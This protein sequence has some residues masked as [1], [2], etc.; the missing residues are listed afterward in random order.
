MRT[1]HVEMPE[2]QGCTATNCAYNTNRACHAKAITVGASTTPG[3][4][5][6]LPQSGH[7][8][9]V[10][11]QAGVGACKVSDCQF[12]RDLECTAESIQVGVSATGVH[13]LTYRPAQG[14][15]VP[16]QTSA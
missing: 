6:F 5:T 7:V 4:A 3:C 10:Q 13:C 8:S 12:N 16:G 1:L 9:D 11:R 15:S 2:V 14:K